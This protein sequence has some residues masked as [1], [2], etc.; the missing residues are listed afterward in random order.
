MCVFLRRFG[1]MVL[2]VLALAGLVSR[3]S[4][5]QPPAAPPG[6]TNG[7]I[8]PLAPRG[9]SSST[10]V[11]G[12]TVPCTPANAGLSYGNLGPGYAPNAGY[13]TLSATYANSG[14]GYASLM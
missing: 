9:P 7:Y 8:N 10:A 14:Q 4:V 2:G 11:L 12:K 13:G 5:G 3:Q 6:P 1:A